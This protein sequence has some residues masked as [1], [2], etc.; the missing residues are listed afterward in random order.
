MFILTTLG[1]A[2]TLRWCNRSRD[3]AAKGVGSATVPQTPSA[4]IWRF[5]SY[6]SFDAFVA[7]DFQ[8]FGNAQQRS[9]DKKQKPEER[10]RG[11]FRYR[12][13]IVGVSP[14]AVSSGCET[15][16]LSHPRNGRVPHPRD[17]GKSPVPCLL[18]LPPA[19]LLLRRF[20]WVRPDLRFPHRH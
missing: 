12:P 13:D 18:I 16:I 5:C 20:G 15:S 10:T 6:E 8:T 17:P 1:S 9:T 11:S 3:M 2:S 14:I 7:V 19:T 4:F